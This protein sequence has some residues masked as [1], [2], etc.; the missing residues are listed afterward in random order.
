MYDQADMFVSLP[1]GTGTFDE[2]I[3][4][5]TWAQLNVFKKKIVLLDV[6]SYWGPFLNLIRHGIEKGFIQP[7]HESLLHVVKSPIDVIKI[8]Y[9]VQ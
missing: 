7:K 5:I 2:T 1:G 8:A 6:E 3:E 4:V 9:Q